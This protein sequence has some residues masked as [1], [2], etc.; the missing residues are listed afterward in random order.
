MKTFE[1]SRVQTNA[2]AARRRGGARVVVDSAACD[3]AK[4]LLLHEINFIHSVDFETRHSDE[5]LMVEPPQPSTVN[6]PKRP[7]GLPSYL[8]GLYEV[9]LLTAEQEKV[10]FRKMNYLKY[11]ANRL[12]IQ[13]DP[14]HPDLAMMDEI[15]HLI[16]EA[17]AVRERIACS[18]LRLVV[19]IAR[20]FA[21]RNNTFDDLVSDGNVALLQA[22]AKFDYSRG[23]RFS[24]YATHAIRR[25]FYR[26]IQQK[27]RRKNRIATSSTDAVNEAIDT[28]EPRPVDEAE[29]QSFQ[30]LI[31]RMDECLD[32]RE[33]AI[34][35]ARYGLDGSD[36]GMTLQMV[37]KRLG[38]CKERV[39]QLQIRAVEKLRQ[40]ADE[41]NIQIP[42]MSV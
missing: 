39:R 29:Y 12:R 10:L 13:L 2:S 27:Q 20:K 15:D 34:L 38:I 11:L 4:D 24:T 40:L 25:A 16:R 9:P 31:E 28:Y 26:Q 42:A 6:R 36:K 8:A 41:L 33:R 1:R 14:V 17:D 7:S 22:I 23:F 5:S 21:D 18:N 37:A 30:R 3:R 35:N 19:S 32:E